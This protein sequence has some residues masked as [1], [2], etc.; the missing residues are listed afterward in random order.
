M[1]V[2]VDSL[3]TPLSVVSVR[4]CEL[5]SLDSTQ[6][7]DKHDEDEARRVIPKTICYCLITAK[8]YPMSVEMPEIK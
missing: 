2:C 1:K 4:E 7:Y 8:S 6:F 5:M 3:H